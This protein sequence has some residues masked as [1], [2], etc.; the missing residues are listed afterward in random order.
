MISE[1]H[2]IFIPHKNKT[3]M[4]YIPVSMADSEFQIFFL[5][6]S[7]LIIP[8]LPLLYFK[9]WAASYYVKHGVPPEMINIGMALYGRSFT[10]K[11]PNVNDVG[12]P[13]RGAGQRGRYTREKGFISYYE[14]KI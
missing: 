7:C 1:S 12:A 14:V 2:I 13:V 8:L 3:S 10:L 9:D 5:L 6:L 4:M 11:D